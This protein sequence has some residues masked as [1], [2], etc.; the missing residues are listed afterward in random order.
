M[1]A[2]GGGAGGTGGSS[3]GG[4]GGARDGSP[5]RDGLPSDA[6]AGGPGPDAPGLAGDAQPASATTCTADDEC[7]LA[8]YTHPVVTE[9]DCYCAHCPSVALDK[10]TAEAYAAQWRQQC[11]AWRL[12][13]PCPIAQCIPP[14]PTRCVAGQC[15]AGA[16]LT[17]ATCPTDST[18]PGGVRCGNLCC[19]PAEWCDPEIG[20]CRCGFDRGCSAGQTCGVAGPGGGGRCGRSCCSGASCPQ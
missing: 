15:K 17:P 18:C 20:I 1:D 13:H 5:P 16:I 11:T 3:M 2:A 9:A 14:R 6:A 8:L 4:S 10:A 12:T 19:Q 7:V